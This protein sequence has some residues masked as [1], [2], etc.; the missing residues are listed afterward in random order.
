[1]K[2]LFLLVAALPFCDFLQNGMVAFGAPAIM[3][4]IAAG[5]REYSA[6]ATAY[7]VAA[8]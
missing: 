8:I 6:A 1:M 2:L 3:G 4:G 5:P 7:A